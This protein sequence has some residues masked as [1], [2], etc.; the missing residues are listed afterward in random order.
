MAVNDSEHK[1][2]RLPQWLRVKT[3]KLQ[4]SRETHELVACHGLHTVCE[5]AR[6]PNIGECYAHGTATF[7]I[8]GDTCTRDCGFCAVNH[9]QPQEVDP[10]EPLRVA[11][12]SA[13]LGLQYVVVTSVTRDDLPDAGAGQFAATLRAIREQSPRARVEV[14]IPDLGGRRELMQIVFNAHPDVFNHNVETVRRLQP[15]VRPQANYERSLG[16]LRAGAEAG[17]RTKSGIMIGLGE[18]DDEVA[19]TLQDLAS[20]G[21]SSVTVGQYLQPT[22]RHLPVERYVSPEGFERYTQMAHEAGITSAFCGP[23]VRSSYRAAECAEIG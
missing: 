15:Q 1:P 17:M 14:L 22:R 4:L 2:G 9:G 21:V 6:C 12:A 8:L 3:G 11:E 20:A 16:V 23:F 10:G 18:A 7:M 5:A 19:Q 13:E